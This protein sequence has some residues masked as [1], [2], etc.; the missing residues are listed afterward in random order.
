MADLDNDGDLDIV[1]ANGHIYPQIDAHP[2]LIGT[3][4]Q[5]NLLLENRALRGE[6]SADVPPEPLFRDATAN[7]GPGFAIARSHRGLAVGDYD[8]DGRLD[9]LV[10]ALDSPPELLHNEGQTGSWLTVA[11][12]VQGDGGA[13]GAQVAVTAGERTMVG[14]RVGDSYLSTHDPRP[15][16]R[17]AEIATRWWSV[18]RRH[19]HR[20]QGR[21]PADPGR[22]KG[23][24]A[25]SARI[26]R[27]PA[28]S[29][30][31]PSP[32]AYGRVDQWHRACTAS[33]DVPIRDARALAPPT[34]FEVHARSWR[35]SGG[36]GNS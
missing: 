6:T 33:R 5:R 21:P 4:R 36:P 32:A 30:K 23:P 16:R 8:N 1:V 27:P 10:T 19:P 11:L 12:K 22:R 28:S 35:G 7:A 2:E 29:R 26:V 20:A 17:P 14:H 31:S 15:P 13:I 9:L 3:Y 34:R 25:G 18:A 24:D